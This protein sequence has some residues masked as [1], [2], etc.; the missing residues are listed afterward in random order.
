MEAPPISSL[1]L[2]SSFVEVIRRILR[3]GLNNNQLIILRELSSYEFKSLTHALKIISKKYNIPLSTLKINAKILKD[4]G[5]IETYQGKQIKLTPA[6][7]IITEIINVKS[8]NHVGLDYRVVKDLSEK[9]S[10]ARDYIRK[11]ITEVDAEYLEYTLSIMDILI[12]LYLYRGYEVGSSKSS[13][14]DRL[15]VSRR[16]I[17]PTLYTVLAIAGLVPE[18]R[19]LSFRSIEELIQK[20][21]E[22]GVPGIDVISQSLGQGLLIGCGMALALKRD[23]IPAKVYVVGGSEEL[24]E[25]RVW[26]AVL[27]ASKLRLDNL[28]L[29]IVSRGLSNQ[30]GLKEDLILRLCISGWHVVRVS[31]YNP[32]ELLRVLNEVNVVGKPSVITTI[33]NYRD[34]LT[35]EC[36]LCTHYNIPYE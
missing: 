32:I 3:R 28:V 21:S 8:F 11:I 6:G 18:G 15:V 22:V 2:G 9:I 20:Y 1:D 13:L 19:V 23:G 33:N 25:E 30:G 12:T 31:D 35:K 29:V 5:I 16:Y 10:L 14:R 17:T 4:L 7:Q 36:E 24:V 26:E 27:V 34:I